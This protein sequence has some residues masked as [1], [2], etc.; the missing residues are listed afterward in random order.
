MN[1]E[2]TKSVTIIGPVSKD[3]GGIS[4]YINKQLK[5]LE[6]FELSTHDIAPSS[7]SGPIWFLIALGGALLDATSYIFSRRSDIVHVH[8]SHNLS[9]ARSSF[10]VLFTKYV[11][12]R[13]V[14]LHIHGSSFH[15]F[16]NTNSTPLEWYQRI[17]FNA[18]CRVI[19]LS[20]YWE[21][22]LSDHVKKSKIE[23]IPNAVNPLEYETN[24]R[25]TVPHIVFIS[26]L[27]SR[28][29]INEL[30]EAIR[31][32]E[33]TDTPEYKVTIAGKGPLS[34]A[35]EELSESYNHVE[36]R[37]YVSEREKQA[38]LESGTIYVLPSYAE[39]LP[40]AILE[41]MAGG[42]AVIST[43]VGSIP[44]VITKEN[45]III[46]PKNIDDLEN[47]IKEL[48]ENPDITTEMGIQSR[49]LCEQK[50]SWSHVN[51]KL[52]EVYEHCIDENQSS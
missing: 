20:T 16:V 51:S 2:K 4:Q 26:N 3:T 25:R 14:V 7:G 13:P 30:V 24:D 34:E 28:K 39:G 45:G 6:G 27:I 44:E 47:A 9:F 22:M 23:A 37:G 48:L 19:V 1:K 35:V 32:I 29:G 40:I 41:G 33:T 12:S 17:V 18:A 50:Y 10:Y 31:K 21:D 46:E 5:Y 15:K 38:I 36:Y 49:K 8:T 52:Q 43:N 42:N 11:W